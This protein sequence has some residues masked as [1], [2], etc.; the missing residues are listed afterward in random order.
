MQTDGYYKASNHYILCQC[1][2]KWIQ[3][4][5]FV[6]RTGSRWNYTL[7]TQFRYWHY[8]F[9]KWTTQKR[10]SQYSIK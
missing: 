4:K 6:V 8:S 2:Y 1:T 9:Y 5:Q 10:D 7:N 3:E